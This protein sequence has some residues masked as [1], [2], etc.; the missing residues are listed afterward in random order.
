MNKFLLTVLSVLMVSG[1]AHAQL[2]DQGEDRDPQLAS[3]EGKAPKRM[4]MMDKF[5]AAMANRGDC[6][7]QIRRGNFDKF[8][9]LTHGFDKHTVGFGRVLCVDRSAAFFLVK[10]KKM[11][12]FEVGGHLAS[13]NGTMHGPADSIYGQHQYEF[14]IFIRYGV[15]MARLKILPMEGKSAQPIS[16]MGVSIGLEASKHRGVMTFVPADPR[17]IQAMFERWDNQPEFMKEA[18]NRAEN[19]GG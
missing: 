2:A 10:Q 13:L 7:V 19:S 3:Q 12:G 11:S 5:K 6:V 15:G 9:K 14:G 4:S 1:A 16:A 17:R 18:Q 8:L